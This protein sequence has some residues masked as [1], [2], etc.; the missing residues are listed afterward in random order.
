VV[1]NFIVLFNG[2]AKGLAA[3][4]ETGFSSEGTLWRM[5]L[6]PRDAAVAALVARVTLAGDGSRLLEMTLQ[7]PNG[8]RSVTRYRDVRVETLS[9]GELERAFGSE[10]AP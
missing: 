8:D 1:E 7:E 3:R 2:D 5:E 4:Y 6:R 9:D 10:G